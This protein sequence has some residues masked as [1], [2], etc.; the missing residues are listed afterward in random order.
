MKGYLPYALIVSVFAWT[1]SPRSRSQ[2]A[3]VASNQPRVITVLA[4]D[5]KASEDGPDPATFQIT[6]AGS[7]NEPVTVLYS[8][9]GTARNGRDYQM[10]SVYVTIAAGSTSSN[11]VGSRHQ[12]DETRLLP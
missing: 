3:P 10:L 9:G 7:T 2:T 8:L 12:H 4:T 11:A 6:R 1:S 5:P